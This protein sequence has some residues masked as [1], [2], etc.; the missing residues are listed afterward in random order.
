VN[1]REPLEV[2][3]VGNEQRDGAPRRARLREGSR[4]RV[5]ESIVAED[6]FVKMLEDGSLTEWESAVESST[7]RWWHRAP[8]V[9]LRAVASCIWCSMSR[10]PH[11]RAGT[12][13]LARM[14][15]TWTY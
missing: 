15:S 8:Q 3:D 12:R 11:L 2:I 10:W 4:R 7:V 14:W 13:R 5:D 9:Q 6:A 1:G